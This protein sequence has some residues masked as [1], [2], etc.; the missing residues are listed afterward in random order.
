MLS[1]WR[2]SESQSEHVMKASIWNLSL[3]FIFAIQSIKKPKRRT[4]FDL[5]PLWWYTWWRHDDVIILDVYKNI[6]LFILQI[7]FFQFFVWYHCSKNF[8][9]RY[10]SF[11][12]IGH[13][14]LSFCSLA[15]SI[16]PKW[17]VYSLASSRHPKMSCL[18]SGAIW[19]PEMSGLLSGAI[20]KPENKVFTF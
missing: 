6:D 9:I 10:K 2:S 16:H 8:S 20:W 1:R 5:Q 11:I 18:L 13:F 7:L 3:N 14:N 19:T 15:P 4:W 12:L 17:V